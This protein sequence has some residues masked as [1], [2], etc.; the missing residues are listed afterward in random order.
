V[1]PSQ[2]HVNPSQSH[3]NP[4]PQALNTL[5]VWVV[6]VSS[7]AISTSDGGATWR[8]RNPSSATTS[9]LLYGLHFFSFNTGC[10]WT[11]LPWIHCVLP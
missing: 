7:T 1:N 4:C 5:E 6:G 10:E 3:V 2:S 11:F 8:A 9:V